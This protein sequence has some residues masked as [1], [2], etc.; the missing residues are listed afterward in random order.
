MD[1]L[2]L[3]FARRAGRFGF[4]KDMNALRSLRS[5]HAE[6]NMDAVSLLNATQEIGDRCKIV[7]RWWRG[8]RPDVRAGWITIGRFKVRHGVL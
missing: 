3:R 5:P 4:Q 7:W 2:T 8:W 6:E 1:V